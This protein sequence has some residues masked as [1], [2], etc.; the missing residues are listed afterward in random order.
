M[1]NTLVA[2]LLFIANISSAQ[3]TFGE[4]IVSDNSAFPQDVTHVE[5]ADLDGD[6]DKDMLIASQSDDLI[7]WFENVDGIGSFGAQNTLSVDVHHAQYA[8]PADL[9]GD[10]DIDVIGVA[11]S[12]NKIV[13]YFNDGLGNFAERII[14]SDSESV[15]PTNIIPADVNVDGKV[16]LVI[17]TSLN[18]LLLYE[19]VDNQGNYIRKYIAE[20]KTSIPNDLEV[21]D[22]DGDGDLDIISASENFNKLSWHEN[23]N[24]NF[25]SRD[26]NDTGSTT[27]FELGDI[28]LDGDLDLVLGTYF[29]FTYKL[30]WLEFD[31]GYD[32][33]HILIEDDIEIS[34]LK[35]ADVNLDGKQDILIISPTIVN[36]VW[37]QNLV[38]DP[39]EISY[40]SNTNT[41]SEALSV[42]DFNGDS[43]PDI[44]IGD[45]RWYAYFPT[46]DVFS[47]SNRF[48]SYTDGAYDVVSMDVDQDGDLDIISASTDDGRIGWFENIDGLGTY[49][50]TQVLIADNLQGITDIHLV[51]LDGDS[52]LDIVGN[53]WR[54]DLVFWIRNDEGSEF[55]DLIVIDDNVISAN[56]VE[57]GD[58]DG[59]G[60]I[61][62]VAAALGDVFD[63]QAED[64]WI[65]WY[66]NMDGMGTFSLP[67]TVLDSTIRPVILKLV[68]I[69]QD[70]DLDLVCSFGS[71]GINWFSNTD[72]LGGFGEANKITSSGTW[73]NAF[74][75]SDIDLDGDLDVVS[76]ISSFEPTSMYI[77]DGQGSFG[78][79]INVADASSSSIKMIDLDFDG[80]MD[81]VT[82]TLS[83]FAMEVVWYEQMDDDFSFTSHVISESPVLDG[84][85]VDVADLDGDGDLDVISASI[86]DDKIA[87][88]ENYD[89][90]AVNDVASMSF[91]VSPVPVASSL[92]IDSEVDLI[93]VI[94]YN[95]EGKLQL[96]SSEV[97]QIDVSTLASGLYI[98]QV[99]DVEGDRSAMKFVKE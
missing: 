70:Q 47:T 98:I 97:N 88:Y 40:I 48:E 5:L 58:L 91:S 87:W 9:D 94:I 74:D 28:D 56:S 80:D 69:D 75:V 79:E 29:D 32:V 21:A 66:Q 78:D 60:D 65:A 84:F 34:A 12:D 27:F 8:R 53:V 7:A 30:S 41:F 38:N 42:S 59:D 72:G 68:D 89:P 95:A 73:A 2:F 39:V 63:S 25:Q 3:L 61:D 76:S 57:A 64:K 96:I 45:I 11:S 19:N 71:G 82:T 85:N 24:G 77:N 90:V 26:I 33:K 46:E 50:P 14:F 10:G 31:N 18:E 67:I 22:I 37:L 15:F 52:D 13:G 6:G 4:H 16:D 93:K 36:I 43:Y 83:D 20:V 17:I 35:V 44:I 23:D 1:K 92:M 55:S 99:E 54:Q 51:D 81:I 49:N 86:T 62:I